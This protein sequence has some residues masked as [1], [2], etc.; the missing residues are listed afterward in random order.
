MYHFISQKLLFIRSQ[1]I[2]SLDLSSIDETKILIS[3]CR[4]GNDAEF[5]FEFSICE[6]FFFLCRKTIADVID[7]CQMA[8]AIDT[9]AHAHTQNAIY[10]MSI[11]GCVYFGGDAGKLYMANEI[12][13]RANE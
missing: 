2:G 12:D 8:N 9:R 6:P 5:T 11:L 4:L 7:L 3:G 13:E 10:I 1:I